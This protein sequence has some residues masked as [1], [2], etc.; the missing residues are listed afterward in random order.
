MN[1]DICMEY[2]TPCP[3]NKSLFCNTILMKSIDLCDLLYY[4]KVVALKFF[5][6]KAMYLPPFLEHKP[7]MEFPQASFF[8]FIKI[9]N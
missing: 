5:K 8:Y 3:F 7:L 4:T 2:E 1:M 6:L 9:P